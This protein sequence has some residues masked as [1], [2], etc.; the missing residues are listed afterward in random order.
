MMKYLDTELIGYRMGWIQRAVLGALYPE[1]Y[2]VMGRNMT[3]YPEK[4]FIV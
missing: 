2:A 1:K 3:P 4:C